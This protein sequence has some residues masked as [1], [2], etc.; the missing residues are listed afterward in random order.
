MGIS[1]ANFSSPHVFLS[2]EPS[3]SKTSKI[4]LGLAEAIP[5]RLFAASFVFKIEAQGGPI[6]TD[7]FEPKGDCGK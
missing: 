6:K 7:S 5:L 2:A 1:F 3:H 4:T